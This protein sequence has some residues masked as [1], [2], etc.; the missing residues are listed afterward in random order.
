MKVVHVGY[1][2][3]VVSRTGGAGIA[4]R[5]IFDAQRKFPVELCIDCVKDPEEPEAALFVPNAWVRSQIFAERVLTRLFHLPLVSAGVV[6]TGFPAF[7]NAQKPDIV[8]L[9]WVRAYAMGVRELAKI[10]GPVVWLL[11]DLWPMLGTRA[12]PVDESFKTTG[13]SESWLDHWVWKE[14]CKA[15]QSMRDRMCVVGPSRWAAKQAEESVVFR[16]CRTEFIPYPLS[17]EF[18]A[19]SRTIAKLPKTRKEKF[20]ILF[21]A[22]LNYRDPIKGYDRL[23]AAL[24]R[25]PVESRK[26]ISVRVFGSAGDPIVENGIEVSFL[27]RLDQKGLIEAYHDA[28]MFS[29]PSRQETWGQTK[30][31]ALSCGTPVV[32][33]DETACAEGITHEVNGWVAAA[34]DIAGYAEGINWLFRMWRKGDALRFPDVTT[35]YTLDAVG[36]QWHDLYRSLLRNKGVHNDQV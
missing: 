6:S 32:A 1:R 34:N 11:H 2:A 19:A 16:G 25:L 18:I 33:F 14:K 15:I 12:Y 36:R 28:D 26:S 3:T 13:C 30:T 23:M 35:D 22:A 4:G 5:R 21:G 9:S 8:Q 27:G 7:I 24:S 17:D 29:F 20:T 10:K 31:E